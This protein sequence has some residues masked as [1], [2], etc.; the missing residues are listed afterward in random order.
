MPPSNKFVEEIQN[1]YGM[2]FGTGMKNLTSTAKKHSWHIRIFAR[3]AFLWE[4][5]LEVSVD[6]PV[7]YVFYS[8]RSISIF[9]F[10]QPNISLQK[11][12]LKLTPDF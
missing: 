2:I 7:C 10:L 6:N 1:L 5:F 12:N 9:A 3:G 11:S 4:V 8:F